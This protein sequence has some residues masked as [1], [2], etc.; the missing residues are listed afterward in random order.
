MDF[1]QRI[2]CIISMPSNCLPII[3]AFVLRGIYLCHKPSVAPNIVFSSKFY[4]LPF[5]GEFFRDV[6]SFL[7]IIFFKKTLCVLCFGHF[8]ALNKVHGVRTPLFYGRGLSILAQ[9]IGKYLYSCLLLFDLA[10]NSS[11]SSHF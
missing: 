5:F 4:N 1:G 11:L 9:C 10:N 2:A 6:G 3:R 7:S 8:L